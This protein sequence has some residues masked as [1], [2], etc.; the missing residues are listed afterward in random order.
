MTVSTVKFEEDPTVATVVKNVKTITARVTA[1]DWT[2]D[3]E[4][5]YVTIDEAMDLAGGVRP[6]QKQ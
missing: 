5:N 1:G 2:T 6:K 4:K 3:F